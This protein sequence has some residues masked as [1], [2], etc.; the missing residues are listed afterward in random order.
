MPSAPE[1]DSMAEVVEGHWVELR[2]TFLLPDVMQVEDLRIVAPEDDEE[3]VGV[4]TEVAEDGTWFELL[5][6]RIRFDSDTKWRDVTLPALRGA[7]VAVEGRYHDPGKFS[8]DEVAAREG[9][10]DRIV[11]RVDAV[12]RTDGLLEL[13]V[14]RFCATVTEGAG[15]RREVELGPLALVAQRAP[16]RA[17]VA[18]LGLDAVAA[19][20]DRDDDDDIP[21]S[22]RLSDELAFGV[23][24]EARH[25]DEREL[26]LDPSDD[27]DRIDDTLSVRTE[28]VWRPDRNVLGLVGLTHEW[29]WRDD[30][31][32]GRE[33]WS[34]S[35]VNE[36]YLYW[37]DLLGSS[38]GLQV[39]RQDFDEEREWL[40]DENLDAL[41]AHWRGDGLRL[42]L[43][44]ATVLADGDDVEEHTD[45]LLAHLTNDDDDAVWGAYVLDKDTDLGSGDE[46]LFYGVRAYGE[47]FDDHDV[48][49]ELAFVDGRS[50][51]TNLDGF[52]FDVGTTWS[53]AALGSWYLIGGYAS[54]SGDDDT[55]DGEDGTFR[56]TGLNDNNAKF[57]G[58]TSF[59]YYGEVFDPH[60]ANLSIVTLG[61]GRRFG[62]NLSL[63]L[64]YHHY[65]QDVALVTLG[66]S[67]LDAD[68]NGRNRTLGDEIDLVF[69][70]RDLG[71]RDIDLEIVLGAFLPGSAFDVEETAWLAQVQLRFGL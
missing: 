64:V 25:R 22:F 51:G 65:R 55:T 1:A 11:G 62:N 71:G 69:G 4:V 52:A 58:V 41:R 49:G 14:M 15:Y 12:R 50:G 34:R 48:W 66:E 43:A 61:A 53:P 54:G 9:G 67:E 8:A 24:F 37:S 5:G 13:D 32:D 33:S 26:D 63:D 46:P 59:R 40:W 2:G 60:L 23:R 47:W 20:D 28:L 42:E 39:G 6:Q 16:S 70:A 10:R 31:E 17:E 30:D 3:L 44:A 27:E 21:I 45:Y 38:W 57:G 7:R 29:R 36:A 56:Q 18:A 19:L 68:P 35:R